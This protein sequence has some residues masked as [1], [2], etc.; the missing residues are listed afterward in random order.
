M[1]GWEVRNFQCGTWR[2]SSV[3]FPAMQSLR[4]IY[5]LEG[6]AFFRSENQIYLLCK[7]QYS[8]RVLMITIANKYLWSWLLIYYVSN[9]IPYFPINRSKR[10]NDLLSYDRVDHFQS[11]L[12]NDNFSLKSLVSTAKVQNRF[13]TNYCCSTYEYATKHNVQLFWAAV[14][15]QIQSSCFSVLFV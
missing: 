3:P 6:K 10:S 1:W 5:H 9:E 11:F 14:T 4:K 7:T 15:F 12:D 8:A 13:V 2:S